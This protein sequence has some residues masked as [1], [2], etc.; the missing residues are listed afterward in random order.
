MSSWL[1]IISSALLFSFS[2]R[3][4]LFWLYLW[5]LKEYRVDRLITHLSETIQGRSLFLDSISVVKTIVLFLLII[6]AITSLRIEAIGYIILIL[7]LYSNLI[8]INEIKNRRLKRPIF[9]L[10]IILLFTLVFSAL[11]FLYFVP[12]VYKIYWLFFVEKLIPFVVTFFVALT[13]LP[14]AIYKDVVIYFA[15]LKRL[16]FKKLIVIGITGSYGKTSTKECIAHFLSHKFNVLKTPDS[17]NTSYTIAKL[18]LRDLSS[19]HEILICEMGAYKKG[20][21]KQ[22]CDIVKPSIAIISGVN[23]QHQSLFGSLD[24]IKSAKFELVESLSYDALSLFNGNS[25][26]CQ[27][28]YNRTQRRKK[29]L[30]YAS[31]DNEFPKKAGIVGKDI[32]LHKFSTSFNVFLK[33]NEYNLRIR[34]NLLGRQSVE[35]LL[36]AIFLASYFGIGHSII[37]RLS[38]NLMRMGKRM[39]LFQHANGYI[40]VDN[41]YNASPDSVRSCL[42][43]LKQYRGKKIIVFQPMIELGDKAQSEH[44]EIAFLLGKVA[45]Y[46]FVTNKNFFEP[47]VDGIRRGSSN[48]CKVVVD[49]SLIKKVIDKQLGRADVVLFLGRESSKILN[50]LAYEKIN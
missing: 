23:T 3:N 40:L 1:Y 35:N 16:R 42:E 15:S 6:L 29:V 10:R 4:I 9:T 48:N 45:D 47:I 30:Y 24:N 44:E 32:R 43:Y 39:E 41:T 7:L 25:I 50:M 28:L 26:N 5:Q 11:V 49:A 14:I 38:R 27:E 8:F 22:I 36:P 18:I 21:I 20:E 19:Y 2:L 13:S 33:S 31:Y 46:V 34:T 17:V 37:S 12:L